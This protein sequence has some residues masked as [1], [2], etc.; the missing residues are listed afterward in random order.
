MPLQLVPREI[1]WEALRF[2]YFR[3][4]QRIERL[5]LEQS[6]MHL[7]RCGI[8]RLMRGGRDFLERQFF[9]KPHRNHA[10]VFLGKFCNKQDQR[11]PVND[12]IDIFGID[13]LKLEAVLKKHI[14][15]Y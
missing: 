14:Q 13:G 12:I 7:G 11:L 4:A 8:L 6:A 5:Q 10:A 1:L 3:A 9:H 15:G 2:L